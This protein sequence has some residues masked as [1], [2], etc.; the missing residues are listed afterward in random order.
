M[1]VFVLGLYI[2]CLW[3]LEQLCFRKKHLRMVANFLVLYAFPVQ[4]AFI[5]MTSPKSAC[6]KVTLPR[7][8]FF[9]TL[10]HTKYL[11]ISFSPVAKRDFR[12]LYLRHF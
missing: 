7:N 1:G 6:H 12:A 11:F 10:K 3:C 8:T 4:Y 5:R 2:S 9:N